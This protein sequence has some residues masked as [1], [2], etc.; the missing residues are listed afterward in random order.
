MSDV[1][2]SSTV[3]P[4]PV[5]APEEDAVIPGKYICRDAQEHVRYIPDNAVWHVPAECC[6]SYSRGR[7]VLCALCKMH[8]VSLSKM[9]VHVL[10]KTFGCRDI[11][12]P[13]CKTL[14]V[15][16]GPRVAMT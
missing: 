16:V 13:R 11:F 5:R 8:V 4:D 1:A 14:C 12:G 7:F 3:G 15:A 10:V 9:C 6:M 2:D